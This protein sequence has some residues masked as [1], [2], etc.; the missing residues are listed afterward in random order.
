MESFLGKLRHSKN[1]DCTKK[2]RKLHTFP[3]QAACSEK[4]KDGPTTF[5]SG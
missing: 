5:A 2:F 1:P 3:R 4:T